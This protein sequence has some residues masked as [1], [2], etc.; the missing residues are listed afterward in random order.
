[1]A[2][3]HQVRRYCWREYGDTPGWVFVAHGTPRLGP[4]G[5]I[6]HPDFAERFFRLPGE[7]DDMVMHITGV[8][9]ICDTWVTP[10]MSENPMRDLKRRKPL[11][12]PWLW[13]DL[14]NASEADLDRAHELIEKGGFL[15]SSGR[16]PRNVHVYVRLSEPAK[17]DV[18][19]SLNR[20]L[21]AYLHADPSPSAINGYLRPAGSLN[22][23]PRVLGTGDPAPVVIAREGDGA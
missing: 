12:W 7:L 21:V 19:A 4:S 8:A 23:K 5:R 18:V 3:M 14:D 1:M 17:P 9:D 22:H 6:E 20:R 11:P 15:V 2:D 13:A 10:A 16:G